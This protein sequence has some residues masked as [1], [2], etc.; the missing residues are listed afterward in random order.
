[1]PKRKRSWT[2][3]GGVPSAPSDAVL[4]K[5]W[6]YKPGRQGNREKLAGN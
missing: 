5:P 2:G 1:M 4:G 6:L 3:G